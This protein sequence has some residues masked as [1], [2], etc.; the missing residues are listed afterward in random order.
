MIRKFECNNCHKTFQ[1]DDQSLVLCPACHSDNVEY[2]SIKIPYKAII[3]VI[4]AIAAIGIG[5]YSVPYKNDNT[6]TN[7]DD[8]I[9]RSDTDS[10]IRD[11][12]EIEKKYTDETGLSIPPSISIQGKMTLNDDDNTYSFKVKVDNL[13]SSI[14]YK[15]I[16][17]DKI[18]SKTI[19]ES[20]DGSFER[21]PPSKADGGIYLIKIVDTQNDSVLC[22]LT[23]DGFLPVKKVGR[24]LSVSELQKLIDSSDE[25]LIGNGENPYLSPDYTINYN[26]LSNEEHQP[27]N[28][29]DVVEKL[30]MGTWIR[31]K[32]ESLTY[33]DTKHI[34]SITLNI[35]K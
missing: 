24:K 18:T 4:I 17:T 10:V 7:N 19:A 5:I 6:G 35:T 28:L 21:I 11:I 31:V 29:A 34:K 8:D 20:K 32:V 9:I 2:Y 23:K 14:T 12:K 25:S 22:Y 3:A 15:V 26:G 27:S 30:E 1:A 33:D 13:P 16:L